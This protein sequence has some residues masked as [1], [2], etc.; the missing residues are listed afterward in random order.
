M[1][2]K[3]FAKLITA[4]LLV[5]LLALTLF[6]C[7]NPGNDNEGT[8]TLVLINGD[9]VKEYVVD[10]SKLPSGDKQSTGLIAVLDYLQ[11]EGK[12]TYSASDG[13]LNRVGNLEGSSAEHTFIA[14][15]T[16]VEKD[17]APEADWVKNITH[18]GVKCTTSIE[19]AKTMSIL[20]D[21]VVILCIDTY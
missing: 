3:N 12:L 21:C 1:K 20:A 14:I 18:K 16:S 11:N 19:G 7:I 4:I 15:Y 13:F 2:T 10:L 17:K 9:D 5:S 6:A 8:M